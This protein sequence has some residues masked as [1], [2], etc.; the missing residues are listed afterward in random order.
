MLS[1]SKTRWKICCAD[2]RLYLY[3]WSQNIY[4]VAALFSHPLQLRWKSSA[5]REEMQANKTDF[6]QCRAREVLSYIMKCARSLELD[7]RNNEGI[8]ARRQTCAHS[9]RVL[10][11]KHNTL[12]RHNAAQ[13]L[14]LSWRR[15]ELSNGAAP[16]D[17]ADDAYN[18]K[19]ILPILF[20]ALFAPYAPIAAGRKLYF[21]TLAFPS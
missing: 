21:H 20:C 18:T 3:R 19:H 9:K 14:C 1:L 6:A 11:I 17:D 8:N 13:L 16:G 12:A 5:G 15:A 4:S 2:E 7:N 10:L